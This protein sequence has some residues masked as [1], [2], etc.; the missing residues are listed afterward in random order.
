M[1][2][3]KSDVDLVEAIRRGE[4]GAFEQLY[5]RFAPRLRSFAHTF[6]G[7][8]DAAADIIQDC[9]VKLWLRRCEL[10]SVSLTS[11]LFTMVRNRCLNH[12]KHQSY[13]SFDNIDNASRGWESL[14]FV[15]FYGDADRPLLMDELRAQIEQAL[16]ALPYRTQQIFRMSRL[17]GMKSRE[18]AEMLQLSMTAVENHINK[19]LT[20]L[21]RHF[22]RN[23][24][25]DLYLFAIVFLFEGFSSW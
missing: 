12:L 9:F 21:N 18:I 16:S 13:L 6:V 5:K 2:N 1:K 25:I 20:Q 7:D 8:D 22:F 4:S 19:S 24:P 10:T 17:Q 23:Y 11:L 14:Y 15:D 3:Y